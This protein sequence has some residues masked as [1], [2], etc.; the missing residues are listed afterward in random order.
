M[1]TIA[2][3][4]LAEYD[5]MIQ[6]GVFDQGKRRRLEFIQ[7]EIREMTPIGSLHEV[8][9]DRLTDWSVRNISEEK[10]WVRVQNS[11][12]FPELQ[13]APQPDVAWVARR[14][15]SQGRPTAEDVLLVVEVAESSLPY[16][17]GEK[18]DL[19]A[20]A[21]IRDYWVVSIPDRS[22]EVRRDPASG[23][24]RNLTTFTGDEEV[25]P[26]AVPEIALRPSQLWPS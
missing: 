26:L 5:R 7:G 11:I 3:L 22:I 16:D 12:G 10:A 15:Y 9:V 17:T 24:Y 19:Y 21:G 4:S 8:V 23:R 18:A 6:S 20:A 1:S 14:D 2:R 25:R 13:S